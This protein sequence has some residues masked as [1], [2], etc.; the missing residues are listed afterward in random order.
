[1]TSSPKV[2]PSSYHGIIIIYFLSINQEK[3]HKLIDYISV[4]P[5]NENDQKS[6]FKF[7]YFASEILTSENPFIID[8]FFEED[9]VS[10]NEKN[11]E[12]QKDEIKVINRG[13]SLIEININDDIINDSENK[14]KKNNLEEN[15][16]EYSNK[17]NILFDFLNSSNKENDNTDKQSDSVNQ[18]SSKEIVNIIS[19]INVNLAG[20]IKENVNNE[21]KKVN[22]SDENII[23]TSIEKIVKT[24]E[25]TK[26]YSNLDYLFR[27]L[28]KE[29]PLN[30]VL[31]GY[32]H[33][34]FNHLSNYKNA[35]VIYYLYS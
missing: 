25:K 23:D 17:D 24:V 15:N 22:Q 7:P 4:E 18:I 6:S 29:G 21:E 3:L 26:I 5:L 14:E 27:F 1:M 32:F 11:S 34:I 9:E 16:S 31:C 33:K 35:H 30:Y 19:E 8:K 10:E 28:S 2:F 20:E 13:S 12:I